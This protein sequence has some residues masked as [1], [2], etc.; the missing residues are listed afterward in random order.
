M[1]KLRR[2]GGEGRGKRDGEKGEGEKGTTGEREGNHRGKKFSLIGGFD[3]LR[4]IFFT[5]NE[6][7]RY[8]Y[9]KH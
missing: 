1:S 5:E 9:T 7:S 3:I 8:L 4:I 2:K 6:N